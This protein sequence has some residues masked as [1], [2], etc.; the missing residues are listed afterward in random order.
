M[1]ADDAGGRQSASAGTVWPL[2]S[3]RPCLEAALKHGAGTLNTKHHHPIQFE[4][5]KIACPR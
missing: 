1:F 2:S 4:R 3:L 5:R